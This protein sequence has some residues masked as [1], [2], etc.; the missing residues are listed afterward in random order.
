MGRR[1]KNVFHQHPPAYALRPGPFRPYQACEGK[2][3]Y[4]CLY[5]D[6]RFFDP[7]YAWFL[8][9]QLLAGKLLSRLAGYT[10][11][12]RIWAE[13]AH[14]FTWEEIMDLAYWKNQKDIQCLSR[15]TFGSQSV[16]QKFSFL[17]KNLQAVSQ[18]AV[19]APERILPGTAGICADY[20]AIRGTDLP[21]EAF[22]EN[23][24]TQIEKRAD[25]ALIGDDTHA[26]WTI[27]HTEEYAQSDLIESLKAF[28]EM[29]SSKFYPYI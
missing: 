6:G 1:T 11:Y 12:V 16:L 2:M 15:E 26:V 22:R 5:E 17:T 4:H 28:C 25:F 8:Q 13:A 20:Y 24:G 18:D 3:S 29:Q 9:T 7:D 23:G 19:L 27:S 21:T 10:F 14:Q